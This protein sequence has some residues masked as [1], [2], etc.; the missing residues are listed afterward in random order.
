[1]R[2]KT[3]L[4]G[5]QQWTASTPT[6]EEMTTK[7]NRKAN[8]KKARDERLQRTKIKCSSFRR[9]KKLLVRRSSFIN[10]S[11]RIMSSRPKF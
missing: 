4:T 1:M 2:K 11:I 10:P 9:R 8:R 6:L 5:A 7:R 3:S